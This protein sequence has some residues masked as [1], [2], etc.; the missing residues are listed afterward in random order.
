MKLKPS[1]QKII[2]NEFLDYIP[3]RMEVT[4]TEGEPKSRINMSFHL[5]QIDWHYRHYLAKGKY[6][7][8]LRRVFWELKRPVD[9]MGHD[10]D[11]QKNLH[12]IIQREIFTPIEKILLHNEIYEMLSRHDKAKKKIE[13]KI[14]SI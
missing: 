5:D 2:E 9:Q 10:A 14:N 4:V 7:Q 6:S 8:T 1:L 11:F 13:K 3:T 12:S